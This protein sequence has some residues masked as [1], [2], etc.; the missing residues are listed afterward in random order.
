M[1]MDV[2]WW[3]TKRRN[4]NETIEARKWQNGIAIDDEYEMEM[5]LKWWLTWNHNGMNEGNGNE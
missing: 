1:M 3:W 5:E 4:S 2:T